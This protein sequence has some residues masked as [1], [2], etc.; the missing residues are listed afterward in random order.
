V[1]GTIVQVNVSRGGIPKRAILSGETTE[2]GITG[3]A[4]RF[5]ALSVKT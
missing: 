2:A 5:P 4:W 1:T 3:D